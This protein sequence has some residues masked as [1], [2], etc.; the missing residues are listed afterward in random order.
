MT[1]KRLLLASPSSLV[2]G[3]P[4]FESMVFDRWGQLDESI[5]RGRPAEFG[6]EWLDSIRFCRRYLR[7]FA[8]VFDLP[9]QHY[10][11]HA[12][13]FPPRQR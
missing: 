4:F 8:T 13:G 3:I 12:G 1:R 10:L 7:L 9:H 6:S 5:R 11:R 2:S